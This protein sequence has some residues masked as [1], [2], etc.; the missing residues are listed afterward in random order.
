[1]NEYTGIKVTEKNVH[2][3]LGRLAYGTV[4]KIAIL[5][6]QDVL[7]LDGRSRMNKPASVEGNWKWRMRG[8]PGKAVE[9]NLRD[10]VRLFGRG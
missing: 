1:L 2:D 8:L 10:M 3:V 9:K 5:P 6:M 4:A 7:G